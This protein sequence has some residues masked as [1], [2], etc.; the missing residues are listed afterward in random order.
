MSKI[1]ILRKNLLIRNSGIMLIVIYAL[2]VMSR[3]VQKKDRQVQE[4]NFHRRKNPDIGRK[5]T[6]KSK[7][8]PDISRKTTDKSRTR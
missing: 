8:N 4:K 6:D 5:T 2:F 7:K 1:S 3:Q